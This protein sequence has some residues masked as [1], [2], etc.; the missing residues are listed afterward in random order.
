[1]LRPYE[2]VVQG[3]QHLPSGG[4]SVGHHFAEKKL[5]KYLSTNK[6]LYYSQHGLPR[7]EEWKEY[8]QGIIKYEE[9][10][11]IL[12]CS[13]QLNL[14]QAQILLHFKRLRFQCKWINTF[15]IQFQFSRQSRPISFGSDLAV[16]L[17]VYQLPCGGAN[18]GHH[19]AEK[20]VDRLPFRKRKKC[21][22]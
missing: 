8:L 3:G 21:L 14:K 1:M 7:I 16:I 17:E 10:I 5:I 9:N 2:V 20:N 4:T 22:S 12:E 13:M 6:K 11:N 19:F 18:Q 15:L